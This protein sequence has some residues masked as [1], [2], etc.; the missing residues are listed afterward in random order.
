M[1]G[2]SNPTTINKRNKSSCS[3]CR[4]QDH[5]AT[6]CPHV[7]IVWNALLDSRIP[8]EYIEQQGRKT[9]GKNN[10]AFRWMRNPY[11]WGDLY[12]HTE[13]AHQLQHAYALRQKNKGLKKKTPR[14]SICG[15][16]GTTGHTRRTCA[17]KINMIALLKKANKNYRQHVY[18]TLVSDKGLSDGALISFTATRADSYNKNDGYRK[19]ITALCTGVNWDTINLFSDYTAT[20]HISRYSV[21]SSVGCGLEKIYNITKFLSSS[22]DLR[23]SSNGILEHSESIRKNPMILINYGSAYMS[24]SITSLDGSSIGYYTKPSISDLKVISRAPQVLSADW[25]NGYSDEMSVIFKKYSQAELDYIGA[26]QHIKEWASGKTR[27]H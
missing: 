3:F 10:Y 9:E 18:D 6:V 5:Q 8:T 4:S 1:K 14:V 20:K 11:M 22:I 19:T 24:K 15:F 27:H 13:R 12:K 23:V 25:I 21:P 2:L 16:C 26:I 17:E 7:P